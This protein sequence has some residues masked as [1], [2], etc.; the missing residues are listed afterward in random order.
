MKTTKAHFNHFQKRVQYWLDRFGMHYL[1]VKFEH[2]QIDAI[3]DFLL[4]HQAQKA[5]IRLTTD[6]D[7]VAT[8]TEMRNKL[9]EASFHEVFEMLL[10][11]LEP[12]PMDQERIHRV[13]NATWNAM[14][15]KK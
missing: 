8:Q 14:Q 2:K 9:E 3:A 5:R 7:S 4:N 12:V 15:V 1:L 11:S 10:I 13:V 6:I